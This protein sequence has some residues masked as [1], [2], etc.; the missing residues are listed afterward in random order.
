MRVERHETET[1]T[2]EVAR[3][4]PLPQLRPY[5]LAGAEGWAQTRGAPPHLREV[6][7]PGVPLIL[8]L[9]ASWQ[10]EDAGVDRSTRR[11]QSFVAGL[12]TA[13]AIVRG[14]DAWACVELR[15]TPLGAHRLLGVPM[16]EL[17]NQTVELEQVLPQTRELGERLREAR[18]WSERFDLVDSF[19]TRRLADSRPTHPGIEWSWHHLY[20]T[21]GR[22][23]IG[24]IAEAL[25]WS[26]RRLIARFREQI[27]LTPKLLA[28]VI[29]FDR[30][31]TA[32]RASGVRGLAEIA[33][34]CGYSDQAHLNRE[35]RELA[36]TS[37]TTFRA[38]RL[39]S[40]GIA[41]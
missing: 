6:P 15:L 17:A 29:R 9:G 39:D 28:R 23:P 11:L 40:G 30:A 34:E 26:H 37:P 24:E 16:S 12:S 4:D 38:A 41:A 33:F 31:V 2:W 21:H 10:I 22:A 7:F 18:R 5:L 20:N 35:F 27:G 3:R 36:G 1:S 13:P 14:A 32:I 25:G 19:L 8:N